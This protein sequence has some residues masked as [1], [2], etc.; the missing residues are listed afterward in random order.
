[1]NKM[2][3]T[4]L[5]VGANAVV[6]NLDERPDRD[7][8]EDYEMPEGYRGYLHEQI[9]YDIDRWLEKAVSDVLNTFEDIGDD[10]A[11]FWE[12]IGDDIA[13]FWEEVGYDIKE[14]WEEGD[15]KGFATWL[16]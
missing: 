1:M 10:I 5:L 8:W 6:L 13:D 15:G 4:F 12:P 3:L 16:R 14:Y 9:I 7:L 11:D 2:S